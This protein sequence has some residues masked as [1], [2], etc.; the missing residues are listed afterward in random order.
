MN[1]VI[2]KRRSKSRVSE[3]QA[4]TLKQRSK[5]ILKIF[6]AKRDVD[7]ERQRLAEDHIFHVPYLGGEQ[8]SRLY[9]PHKV[10]GECS[11]VARRQLG[12]GKFTIPNACRK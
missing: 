8:Q 1:I 9:I 11:L 12:M 7:P 10:L 5:K 2:R 3:Q 6:L 4:T